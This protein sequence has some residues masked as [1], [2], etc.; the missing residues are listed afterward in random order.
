M[1]N[2]RP[3]IGVTPYAIWVKLRIIE[4]K[5][6]IDEYMDASMEIPAEW[7]AEYNAWIAERKKNDKT[8]H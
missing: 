1:L 5:R 2:N 8:S 7:V 3:P 6:A 4:L